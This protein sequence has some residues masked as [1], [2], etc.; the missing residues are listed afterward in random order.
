MHSTGITCADEG[1]ALA[2]VKKA[3]AYAHR[4]VALFADGERGIIHRD[5]LGG[6]NN[7]NAVKRE[8]LIGGAFADDGF[9]TD[10]NNTA[11]KFFFCKKCAFDDL[12]RGVI[13]THSVDNNFHI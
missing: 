12:V 13:A 1:V 5:D 3:E 8:I 10:E 6:V 7:L 4:G 9:V 2:L 11:G